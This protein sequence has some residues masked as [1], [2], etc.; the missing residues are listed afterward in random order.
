MLEIEKNITI[1]IPV[2]NEEN[3]LREFIQSIQGNTSEYNVI[4]IDDGST[5]SSAIIIKESG[6]RAEKHPYNMGYGA[7]VKTGVRNA[8]SEYILI[9]DG[10][11]QHTIEG[12]E[13]FLLDYQNYDMN[14]GMRKTMS[15]S[16]FFRRPLKWFM[17]KIVNYLTGMKVPD[18]NS[19]FRLMKKKLFEE[20]IHLYPNTF[21]I[22]TTATLAFLTSGYSVIWRPIKVLK[23]KGGKSQVNIIKDSIQTLLLIIRSVSLFNPLKVFIPISLIIFLLGFS[24]LL[25]VLITVK[26]IADLSV[27]LIL[28][29]ML[30]FFFGILADQISLLRKSNK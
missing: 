15:S 10:D 7:A 6:F 3:S 16:P 4:F 27:L 18:V 23:R 12:L 14:L 22:S 19:G 5:D 2:Y 28:S 29:S 13:E 30:I 11:G 25:Y 24:N 9:M 26:D 20:F 1:V 8:D 21:S 17:N